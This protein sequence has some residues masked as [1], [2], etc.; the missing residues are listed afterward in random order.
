MFHFT[1][2]KGEVM[3]T[4]VLFLLDNTGLEQARGFLAWLYDRRR[5]KDGW[6]GEEC[7]VAAAQSADF[8]C[9]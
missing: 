2:F 5:E 8:P 4:F 6:V 3:L 9:L 7:M 1:L